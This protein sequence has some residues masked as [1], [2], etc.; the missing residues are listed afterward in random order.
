LTKKWSFA[1][2]ILIYVAQRAAI[3]DL[4]RRSHNRVTYEYAYPEETLKLQLAA[5]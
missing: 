3:T 1:Q 2:E 4:L 5:L